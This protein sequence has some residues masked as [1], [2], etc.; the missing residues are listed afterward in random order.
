MAGLD[1]FSLQEVIAAHIRAEFPAYEVIEDDV[2]DDEY[3]LRLDNNVKPFIF[4]RWGSL[5]R[6][7]ANASFAGVRLDE[8]SSTVDIAI[9]APSPRIARKASNMI[10]DALIG[11]RVP[12]GNSLTPDISGTWAV[13]DDAGRPHLYVCNSRFTYAVNFDN[14]GAYITP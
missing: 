9:V 1:L 14:V 2:I 10:T 12:G 8:Y 5:N 3:I 6:S 13:R 4:L 11:W 7:A